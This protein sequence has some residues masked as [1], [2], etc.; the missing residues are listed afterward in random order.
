MIPSE[1]QLLIRVGSHRLPMNVA[2]KVFNHFSGLFK[3]ITQL[4]TLRLANDVEGIMVTTQI[5]TITLEGVIIPPTRTDRKRYD[6]E[7]ST[8]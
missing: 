4:E 8:K 1:S 6:G 5:P 2:I 3:K 7:I